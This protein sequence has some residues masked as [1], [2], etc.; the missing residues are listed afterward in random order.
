[1]SDRGHH[2]NPPPLKWKPQKA[3]LVRKNLRKSPSLTPS[4]DD[5]RSWSQWSGPQREKSKFHSKPDFTI[6]LPGNDESRRTA[7][8][9]DA[10]PTARSFP[11]KIAT[12]SKGIQRCNS[13]PWDDFSFTKANREKRPPEKYRFKDLIDT[14]NPVNSAS[15]FN[16]GQSM[17]ELSLNWV[18]KKKQGSRNG[19]RILRGSNRLL[20]PRSVEAT[21]NHMRRNLI[22]NTRKVITFIGFAEEE[23]DGSLKEEEISDFLDLPIPPST[24][25]SESGWSVDE[26]L[27]ET[28]SIILMG[29]DFGDDNAS[30]YST[31]SF[32]NMKIDWL[33]SYAHEDSCDWQPCDRQ[34][35]QTMNIQG[36]DYSLCGEVCAQ[37]LEMQRTQITSWEK[38]LPR[39]EEVMAEK[40]L[41]K[42]PYIYDKNGYTPLYFA[43]MYNYP[44]LVQE[45]LYSMDKT[46][47]DI[48]NPFGLM[49]ACVEGYYEVAEILLEGR[50]PIYCADGIFPSYAHTDNI[51]LQQ[52]VQQG[53]AESST[54]VRI[55]ALLAKFITLRKRQLANL[56][57]GIL[58]E[59]WDGLVLQSVINILVEFSLT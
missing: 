43:I 56:F 41:E 35:T 24:F 22:H 34:A 52:V 46:V 33:P 16:F 50:F 30:V 8:W 6:I 36:K 29:E 39:F 47:P 17:D 55:R 1:M 45:I 54:K 37:K 42:I 21:G 2:T 18:A 59:Q 48:V 44:V 11:I 57:E 31:T 9:A 15:G 20:R 10:F 51:D 40:Y 13:T 7:D 27:S 4:Y 12:N 14:P 23:N 25:H 3:K 19:S 28:N 32:Q 38:W 26:D 49:V 53:K 5:L 58:F